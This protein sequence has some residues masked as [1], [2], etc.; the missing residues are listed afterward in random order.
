MEA[1]KA[2]VIQAHCLGIE[3]Q[4]RGLYVKYFDRIVKKTY[5][6]K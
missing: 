5:L 6:R 2:E 1:I 3:P 4:I